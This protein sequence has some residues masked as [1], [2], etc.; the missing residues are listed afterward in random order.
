MTR[1]GEQRNLATHFLLYEEENRLIKIFDPQVLDGTKEELVAVAYLA[2]R[3]LNLNGEN[4]P[5]M[6]EVAI[7]LEGIDLFPRAECFRSPKS[8][9]ILSLPPKWSYFGSK[10][11]ISAAHITSGIRCRVSSSPSCIETQP[12]DV[13]GLAHLLPGFAVSWTIALIS[14]GYTVSANRKSANRSCS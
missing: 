13:F 14:L 11:P 9:Y 5:A 3:C 6:E 10:G 4:R 2:R 1:T 12:S 8:F 7:E